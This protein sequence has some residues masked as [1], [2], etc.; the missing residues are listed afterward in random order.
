MKEWELKTSPEESI[1]RVGASYKPNKTEYKPYENREIYALDISFLC[2]LTDVD[3]VIYDP[4][5]F[6][7]PVEGRVNNPAHSL[8]KFSEAYIDNDA[9]DPETILK[10]RDHAA[11]RRIPIDI[12]KVHELVE[13]L[14]RSG[15][16]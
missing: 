13:G 2:S 14:R 1:A 5:Y 12:E 4:I 3:K 9:N 11:E 7:I 16:F 10:M 8:I 15:R 6:E